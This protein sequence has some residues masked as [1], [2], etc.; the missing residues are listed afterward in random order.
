MNCYDGPGIFSVEASLNEHYIF[1]NSSGVFRMKI[2][3]VKEHSTAFVLFDS[4][5]MIFALH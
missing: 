2:R 3:V 1:P 4:Q 5:T